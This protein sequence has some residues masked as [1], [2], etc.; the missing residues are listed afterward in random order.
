[1]KRYIQKNCNKIVLKHKIVK[2]QNRTSCNFKCHRTIIGGKQPGWSSLAGTV[3]RHQLPK[4]PLLT[5]FWLCHM[6]QISSL[7]LYLII[8]YAFEIP[9]NYIHFIIGDAILRLRVNFFSIYY[10]V[11]SVCWGCGQEWLPFGNGRQGR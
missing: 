10:W 6:N 9:Q 11:W 5:L 4:P 3:L 7:D 8:V 1:M 2:Q